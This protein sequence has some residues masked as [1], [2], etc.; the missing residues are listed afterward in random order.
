MSKRKSDADIEA[1]KRHADFPAPDADR[2]ARTAEAIA[3]ALAKQHARKRR[4]RLTVYASLAVL[5]VLAWQEYR[6]LEDALL[7]REAWRSVQRQRAL[8]GR[9]LWQ[10]ELGEYVHGSP[11]RSSFSF[12]SG[13][14][15]WRG[16]FLKYA[17]YVYLG[18][19][20]VLNGRG[21]DRPVLI[22]KEPVAVGFAFDRL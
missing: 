14:Y 9:K 21:E 13:G 7:T 20:R 22:V 1:L 15:T 2:N 6:G 16:G 3:E 4:R 11:A 10:S 17:V 18:R 19:P 5:L 8:G 12:G